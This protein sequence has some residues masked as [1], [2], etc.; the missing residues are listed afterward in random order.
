[1]V[2]Q[3]GPLPVRLPDL[4][5]SDAVEIALIK[6]Q[7]AAAN[8]RIEELV[9]LMYQI[10][11]VTCEVRE[12][13]RKEREREK[14]ERERKERERGEREREKQTVRER[15]RERERASARAL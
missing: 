13:E 7:L 9:G 5:A 12:K 6:Q 14:G 4:P 8:A 3:R 2:E 10:R 11:H 1:M 15:E